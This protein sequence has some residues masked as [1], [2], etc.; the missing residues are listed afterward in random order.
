MVLSN[1]RPRVRRN[2]RQVSNVTDNDILPLP[3]SIAD[4]TINVS[5][6]THYVR[7]LNIIDF[8]TDTKVEAIRN[9]L[10]PVLGFPDKY[11]F[12]KYMALL[13]CYLSNTIPNAP[14]T[15]ETFNSEN[16]VIT[17]LQACHISDTSVLNAARAVYRISRM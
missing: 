6:K 12:C 11:S 8:S 17:A 2:L 10:M 16:L 1:F 9:V 15:S 3:I 4:R 13:F 7:W 14:M 5:I